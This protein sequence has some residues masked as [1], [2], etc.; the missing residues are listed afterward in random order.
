MNNNEG[1]L[2]ILVI[3]CGGREHAIAQAIKRSK[4]LVKL[5]VFGG[6]IN[7]ALN[8]IADN[9]VIIDIKN[10]EL[11]V[12]E[13]LELEIDL[14]I[15]G[16]EAPLANGLADQLWK[17][18]IACVGPTKDYAQIESS[19]YFSRQLLYEADLN[20]YS[21]EWVVVTKENLA[22]LN[23]ILT[24]QF[25][26][27]YVIKA[28][29]LRGGKGVKLSG[30]DFKT[31]EEGIKYC[32]QLISEDNYCL[33]EEKLVGEEF[34]L[35]SLC[36]GPKLQHFPPVQ[37]Y[38][39][40]YDDDLGPNTGG[41]GSIILKDNFPF[42]N[43]DDIHRAQ[44]LNEMVVNELN[45][46][47]S[48]S[49][50]KGYVGIL[51]GSYMKTNSGDIKIIEYNCRFG[52]PEAINLL[53][54]LESDFVNHMI[55]MV[56][57]EH[58][59]TELKL[60][61]EHCLVRYVCPEGYPEKPLKNIEIDLSGVNQ[62]YLESE[63]PN[64]IMASLEQT[65]I[66]NQPRMLGSRAL[67]VVHSGTDLDNVIADVN[68][69][70]LQ[71]KGKVFF[72]LDIGNK[73][74]NFQSKSEDGLTYQEAGVNIDEANEA[75][76][77]IKKLVK[78]THLYSK[79]PYKGVVPNYGH[80]A[81]MYQAP[82]LTL[83]SSMDGVGTK[84]HAVLWLIDQYVPENDRKMA[85]MHAFEA[86]GLD[87]FSSN[88]N[89]LI[90]TARNVQPLFFMD[91]F[92]AEQL[93]KDELTAFVSGITMSCM[94]SGYALLGGETAELKNF[95]R[96]LGEKPSNR[97]YEMVGT[98]T[99]YIDQNDRY[100]K[101]DII[102]GD[103]VV[104][105]RSSGIHTNGYTLINHLL[106][107]GKLDG[108]KYAGELCEPHLNYEPLLREW[109][110]KVTFKGLA[111]ITGGGFEDNPVRILPSGVSIEWYNWE[112][113]SV[114]KAIQ[115]A[116]NISEQEMYRTFN[117]GIGMIAVISH[118]EYEKLFSLDQGNEFLL[119]GKVVNN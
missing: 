3:G 5:F 92:S 9:Y 105:L 55:D 59:Q 4:E 87:L 98:I 19:K 1:Y 100:R 68:E 36:G 10:N 113:P 86:L 110:K 30:S 48:K 44:Q 15:I 101:E 26:N 118:E 99:G 7:P 67:A 49:N 6:Y 58:D 41:M 75:M 79:T 77:A 34:S 46:K 28:D 65:S 109:E 90:C 54:L 25:N 112:W 40:A 82:G 47:F 64:I 12:E 89:D 42:L 23:N 71:I 78:A 56:T 73:Y 27:N 45:N 50:D 35:F 119:V 83:V 111:H 104:G 18:E 107:S 97:Q 39:K 43:N 81:G 53:H 13:A 115:A 80:F 57:D 103:W 66:P 74:L 21:P 117:C 114:F 85:R 31:V 106:L 33:I 94:N 88:V 62:E 72:R 17:V 91:Y 37:D 108:R 11:V 2:N 76:N 95:T 70:L 32:Q 60:R 24:E 29:G 38:K 61:K 8:Q 96:G 20:R 63:H 116:G 16:P 51:Y 102:P 69:T 52:D 22:N 14:A 84:V 93:N